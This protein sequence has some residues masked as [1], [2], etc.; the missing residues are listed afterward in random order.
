MLSFVSEMVGDRPMVS[1]ITNRKSWVH[2]WDVSLWMT[3]RGLDMRPQFLQWISAYV[4]RFTFDQQPSSWRV[5]ACREGVFLEGQPLPIPKGHDPS[6]VKFLGPLTHIIWPRVIKFGIWGRVMILQ[7]TMVW[8]TSALPHPIFWDSC[9]S[10]LDGQSNHVLQGVDEIT[11][12]RV[13]HA[14][15]CWSRPRGQKCLQLAYMCS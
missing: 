5:N 1:R 15:R 14:H 6:T 3:L 7:S 8:S 10:P 2:D 9:I 4:Q 11:F 13:Y 12:Y